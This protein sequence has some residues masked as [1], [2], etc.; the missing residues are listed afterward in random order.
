MIVK[1]L[2]YLALSNNIGRLTTQ[3]FLLKKMLCSLFVN[4]L[5]KT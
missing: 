4:E 1:V 5:A 2:H 3:P